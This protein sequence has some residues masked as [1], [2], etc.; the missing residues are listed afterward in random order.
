MQQRLRRLVGHIATPPPLPPVAFTATTSASVNDEPIFRHT[1]VDVGAF[2]RDGFMAHPGILT[3]EACRKIL[4]SV[5]LLQAK[6]DAVYTQ[7]DW[8]ALPWGDFGLPGLG[9]KTVT[10]QQM[11]SMCGGC[12]L[13]M[14][15]PGSVFPAGWNSGSTKPPGLRFAERPGLPLAGHEVD[16]R[17]YGL[18][19]VLGPFETHGFLPA[20]FPLAYDSFALEM[21]CHPQMLDVHAQMIGCDADALRFDH[22]LLM[23]RKP[24][25]T[26]GGRTWHAH[27]YDQDGWGPCTRFPGLGLIRTLIYP[28]GSSVDAGGQLAVIPGY[29]LYRDPFK[30]K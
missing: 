5:K 25:G 24:G 17:P 13:Q 30:W 12:E 26:G 8:N 10:P 15:P 9:A 19:G 6:N 21:A 22:S 2:E 23:N 7:T 28:E 3:D 14:S 11:R 29:H 16:A 20:S 1:Q 27:P 18:P 4:R